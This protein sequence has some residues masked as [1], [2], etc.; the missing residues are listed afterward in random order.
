MIWQLI[1]NNKPTKQS[2]ALS[3]YRWFLSSLFRLGVASLYFFLD[4]SDAT[5]WAIP[6]GVTK[7]GTELDFSGF[8]AGEI[9]VLVK[10]FSAAVAE[11]VMDFCL[12]SCN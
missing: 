10:D 8:Q 2:S 1:V 12:H 9:A 6:I 3:V 7:D 4:G 11:V 5:D